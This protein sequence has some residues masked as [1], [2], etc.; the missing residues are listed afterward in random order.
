MNADIPYLRCWVRLPYVSNRPGLEEGYAFAIQSY[1]GRALAFHVMLKSGA[2]YRGVPIHALALNKE[3]PARP[4]HHCQLWDCFTFRPI[5]HVYRY[6]QGHEAV[7]YTRG[8]QAEGTYLFTVDWL[9][10]HDGPGFTHRPEQNK[11]AHV[12]ALD[13]GNLAALPT[14]RIAWKD[15]YFIGSKPNPRANGYLVQDM[16]W[17]AE[18]CSKFDASADDNY[19]YE[20]ER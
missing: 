20:D 19:I 8:G 4:L 7:C 1:P 5:V 12:M 11:C 6:L 18:D 2:H 17:Q 16:V 15:G 14:N 13:D 9:P 3:A 10:D